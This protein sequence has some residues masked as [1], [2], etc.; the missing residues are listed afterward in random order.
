MSVTNIRFCSLNANGLRDPL[1]RR[2]VFKELKQKHFDVICIQETHS[3]I[4][5]E[6]FWRNEWGGGFLYFSHG[7]SNARGSMII[8]NKS[9]QGK[10]SLLFH[11]NNGRMVFVKIETDVS[12]Y[13]IGSLY[14][15]TRDKAQDQLN[16]ISLVAEKME[17][18]ES[19]NILLG[20]DF[21]VC[22][23]ND[24]D[25]SNIN[26]S[27]PDSMYLAAL[28]NLIEEIKLCDIWRIRNVDVKQYSYHKGHYA[29]RLDYWFISENISGAV[30][31][32]EIVVTSLSDHNMVALEL[33]SR[34]QSRGP[35]YWKFN[36]LLLQ[37]EEYTREMSLYIRN[38]NREGGGLSP[39]CRW[40]FL[41]FSIR[42]ETIAYSKK[43]ARERNAYVQALKKGLEIVSRALDRDICNANTLIEK[44]TIERE[45][46]EI[47]LRQAQG[48]IFRTK[49]NWSQLGERCTKYFLNIEKRNASNK[50]IQG[51]ILENN[52][53]TTDPKVI[54]QE[55][56]IFFENLYKADDDWSPINENTVGLS[57]ENTP[58]LRVVQQEKLEENISSYKLF[59]ALCDMKLGKCPGS[60]GLSAEFYKH[61]WFELSPYYKASIEHS[62]AMNELSEEQK[63]GVITLIPKKDNDRRYLKNWRPISLL[64][65][66]YKIITKAM[67]KRLQ[68]VLSDIIHND[69][70]AY[71]KGRNIGDGIRTVDDIINH[72]S[73]SR[74]K[75]AIISL[76]FQ[77][78][79]DSLRWEFLNEALE[80]FGFGE[81]FRKWIGIF[82]KN[83]SSTVTNNGFMS[84]YFSPQRGVR[85]GCCISPFL[86]I[87]ALE[88]LAIRIRNNVSIVGYTLG[89][90]SC[91]LSLFADDI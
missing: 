11:D 88:I 71:V 60:D 66:D 35:G 22:M 26:T 54:L 50:C 64:N 10:S 61:F 78:A 79:F 55:E 9:F 41:K 12:S 70:K 13:V 74:I 40:D 37:D 18:L 39:M 33:G 5:C 77:K 15:P 44:Q 29:S 75:G 27:Y 7:E 52:V 25:C 23:N 2:A 14:A 4:L 80:M 82:F 6:K 59:E 32:V 28:D 3:T 68:Q 20:G 84:E 76:D 38:F 36:A 85:Q 90:F 17:E 42:K 19:E 43:R 62:F 46:K 56:K 67:A 65:V 8:I 83:I 91:K 69:Q 86:F 89:D 73:I 58:K 87:I 16:F 49:S 21:N 51:L 81:K 31:K 30:S 57:D 63:R 34:Q 45:L 53:F 47:E 24:M 1:K 48:A 72:S